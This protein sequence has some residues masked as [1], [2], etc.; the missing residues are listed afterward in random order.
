MI[1]KLLPLLTA[2]FLNHFVLDAQNSYSFSHL[3]GNTYS[4][5]TGDSAISSFDANGLYKIS[6]LD[7]ET[8]KVYNYNF[9]FGG[10]KSV[11]VGENPFLRFDN[12]SALAIVDVAFTYCDLIDSD[13]K[14]SY[15]IEG[16]P[17]SRILKTQ[18]KNL[19]LLYGAVGNYINVQ[20]W[21]H[22]AT[23]VIELHYGPRSASNASGFNTTTGPQVGIFYS[24]LDFSGCYGKLWCEG[25]PAA[26]VLDSVSNY[27]FD[28]MSGIPPNGT[29]YRF[30]PRFSVPLPPPPPPPVDTTGIRE[31][32]LSQVKVYPNPAQSTIRIEG[33]VSGAR[34]EITDLAGKV[35]Y[36]NSGEI[37]VENISV[38]GLDDGI[39]LLK[40]SDKN[41]ATITKVVVQH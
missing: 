31:A 38:A 23:G 8:F 39:Y 40:I 14:I 32:G 41:V 19:E 18:Y 1:K 24:P 17:G 2:V 3:T 27:S 5:L 12:G 11:S 10:Q 16:L 7:G 21:F 30:T 34:I 28:A 26:L 25:S 13:S 15:K 20:I 33:V 22:Q 4:D 29:I 6:E 37:P 36:E 9:L 35:L